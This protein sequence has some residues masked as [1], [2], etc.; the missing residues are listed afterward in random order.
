MSVVNQNGIEEKYTHVNSI[1]ILCPPPTHHVFNLQ[2]D[3][4]A[5]FPRAIDML[6]FFIV[7]FRAYVRIRMERFRVN[8][9]EVWHSNDPILQIKAMSVTSLSESEKLNSHRH[10]T[11]LE[12]GGSGM[13][14][15]PL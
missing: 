6:G 4:H 5:S 13:R 11:T 2:F 9:D 7:L 8:L 15:P 12:P 3:S 10:R 1:L 14:L